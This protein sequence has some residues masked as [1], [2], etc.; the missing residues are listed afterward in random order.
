MLHSWYKRFP[1]KTDE[2]HEKDK[3]P[4]KTYTQESRGRLDGKQSQNDVHLEKH[5]G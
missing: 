2:R 1:W 4:K 3:K 5:G